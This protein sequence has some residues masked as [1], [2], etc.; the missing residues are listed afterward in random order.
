MVKNF[1]VSDNPAEKREGR[2]SAACREGS[3][4][5]APYPMVRPALPG[6]SCFVC[7]K[8]GRQGDLIQPG[9]ILRE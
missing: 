7:A 5:P 2:D 8:Y 1:T 6:P 4:V 9:K 3:T